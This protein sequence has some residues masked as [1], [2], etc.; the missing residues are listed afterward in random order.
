MERIIRAVV[1]HPNGKMFAGHCH[2]YCHDVAFR[3]HNLFM[4][5]KGVEELFLTS[6]GRLLDRIEAGEVA[7]AAGQIS[8]P[9][10]LESYM[11][12]DLFS[13]NIPENIEKEFEQ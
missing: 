4:D 6:E 8:K 12:A 11:I 13:E 3:E 9:K 2:G 10:Y 1:R 5:A 7:A